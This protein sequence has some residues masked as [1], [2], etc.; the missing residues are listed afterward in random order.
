M[1]VAQKMNWILWSKILK[2]RSIIRRGVRPAQ[3]EL[4]SGVLSQRQKSARSNK[5]RLRKTN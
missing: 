2:T 5:V 3:H 1:E 4:K